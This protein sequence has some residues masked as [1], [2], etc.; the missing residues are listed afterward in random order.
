MKVVGT[1]P[2]DSHPPIL[3][4]VA[5]TATPSP[6]PGRSSIYLSLDLRRKPHFFEAQGFRR[7]SA[8]LAS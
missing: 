8:P 4:P 3:Y 7:P 1:F 2:A 6:T 5:L